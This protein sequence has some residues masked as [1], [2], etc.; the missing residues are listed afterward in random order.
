MG[1][2]VVFLSHSSQDQ[3]ILGRLKDALHERTG[4]TVEFFLS[5]DGESIPLGRNWVHKIEEALTSSTVV[6]VFLS[7]TSMESS[8][9]YFEAGFAYK[10]QAQVVP[11][12]ILGID[13]GQLPPPIGLLQGF[14]LRT[15]DGLNNIIALINKS[16]Q[17]SHHE[18]FTEDD[19][20]RIFGIDTPTSSWLGAYGRYVSGLELIYKTHANLSQ[21]TIADQLTK[22]ELACQINSH[23]VVTYGMS[24]R[25]GDTG[26]AITIDP[27]HALRVFAVIPTLEGGLGIEGSR[28][29]KLQL[30]FIPGVKPSGTHQSVV[31]RLFGT[32]LKLSTRSGM[33]DFG[34]IQVR[35][36]EDS[37][38]G[39]VMMSGPETPHAIDLYGVHGPIEQLRLNVLLEILF[40]SQALAYYSY[41]YPTWR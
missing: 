41:T 37:P 31:N 19:Y 21:R 25:T 20:F 27:D 12:A 6:L 11:I 4:G 40:T 5:S 38:R 34:D 30:R 1:K 3:P 26:L 36:G 15:F 35:V 24:I 39:F 22:A 28:P 29:D 32:E 17:H 8:W 18:S 23:E 9:L 7:P 10:A 2:P 13:L 33:F 16:F 14:N